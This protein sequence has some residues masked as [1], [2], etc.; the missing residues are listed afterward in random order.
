MSE[1]VLVEAAKE[2]LVEML[3]SEKEIVSVPRELEGFGTTVYV[4]DSIS[5][6]DV[7]LWPIK[8]EGEL[9][10]GLKEAIEKAIEESYDNQDVNFY[11]DGDGYLVYEESWVEASNIIDK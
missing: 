2:K 4:S 3:E 8:I 10:D 5:E 11:E 1:K 9:H 6:K 7:A